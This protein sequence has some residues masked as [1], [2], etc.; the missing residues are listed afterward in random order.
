MLIERPGAS[1]PSPLQQNIFLAFGLIIKSFSSFGY[2]VNCAAERFGDQPEC[3]FT[4]SFNKAA[5]SV[6]VSTFD[7]LRK[8]TLYATKNVLTCTFDAF[9]ESIADALGFINSIFMGFLL[10]EFI[11]KAPGKSTFA[12]TTAHFG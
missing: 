2:H 4:N 7:W 10:Y 11:I 6:L 5:G 9:G 3:S 12:P 8:N 1:N